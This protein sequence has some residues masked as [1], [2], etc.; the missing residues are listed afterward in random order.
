MNRFPTIVLVASASLALYRRLLR[1][2]ILTWGATNEEA[3]ARLPGDELLES[4]DG[5]STR[6]IKRRAERLALGP[7]PQFGTRLGDGERM[8]R[9][10]GRRSRGR[11]RV[12]QARR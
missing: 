7:P 9:A 10:A 3:T 1:A 6:A 12:R 2:P 4:A 8:T 11:R 5:V